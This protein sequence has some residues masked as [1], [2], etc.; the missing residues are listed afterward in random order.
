M[1]IKSANW[2]VKEHGFIGATIEI[3]SMGQATF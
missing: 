1:L 2:V 3:T